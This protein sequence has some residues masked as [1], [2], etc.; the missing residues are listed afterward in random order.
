MRRFYELSAEQGSAS[1]ELRLGDYAYYGAL[2][3][4]G[5]DLHLRGMNLQS[6]RTGI[7]IVDV[8]QSFSKSKNASTCTTEKIL[9]KARVHEDALP[10]LV[11]TQGWLVIMNIP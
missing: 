4:K 9:R 1:S 11:I 5:M 10:Y 2:A 6:S 3:V 7:G 8:I